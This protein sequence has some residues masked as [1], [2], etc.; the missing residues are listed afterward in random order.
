MIYELFTLHRLRS[1]ETALGPEEAA[2]DQLPEGESE[3]HIEYDTRQSRRHT[4]VEPHEALATPD[5]GEAAEEALELVRVQSL[6]VGLHHV[7]RVVHHHTAEAGESARQEVGKE[8]PAYELVGDG[9]GFLVDQESNALVARLLQQ[10][11][12]EA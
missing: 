10:S 3:G 6:H 4:L 5:P 12:E 9:A 8:L 2:D 11:G 7:H 1:I